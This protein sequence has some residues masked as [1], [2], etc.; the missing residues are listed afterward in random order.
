[1]ILKTV[2]NMDVIIFLFKILCSVFLLLL[3]L[4]MIQ[5]ALFQVLKLTINFVMFSQVFKNLLTDFYLDYDILFIYQILFLYTFMILYT[6][7]TML[8]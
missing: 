4:K 1:M 8:N 6:C 2:M 5:D 7:Y 3:R